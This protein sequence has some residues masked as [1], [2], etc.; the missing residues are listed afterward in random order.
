MGAV[1][2]CSRS[3]AVGRARPSRWFRGGIVVSSRTHVSSRA[4]TQFLEVK[5]G[6][7]YAYRRF[8]SSSGLP[9]LLLQHVTG[10][11]DNWDSAL[12]DALAGERELI[13]FDN[14]GDAHVG[15][16]DGSGAGW[17]GFVGTRTD[18]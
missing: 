1:E 12:T 16:V 15:A 18:Q 3:N 8:G 14:A 6:E 2:F 4:R 11:L 5:G 13:L 9:L 10:T 7:R 17:L